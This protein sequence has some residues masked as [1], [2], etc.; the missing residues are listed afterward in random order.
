MYSIRGKSDKRAQ[1]PGLRVCV[2]ACTGSVG[3]RTKEQSSDR[4][5]ER[6]RRERWSVKAIH[7][8]LL[9]AAEKCKQGAVVCM[10]DE[11]TRP[12][13]DRDGPGEG[14]VAGDNEDLSDPANEKR[15]HIT[16]GQGRP[17]HDCEASRRCNVKH[18]GR[19]T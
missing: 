9:W 4:C 18:T 7:H 13:R 15:K 17:R 1:T 19:I 6:A 16:G 8:R 11:V 12:A 3:Q 2:S 5:R 14:E 10:M